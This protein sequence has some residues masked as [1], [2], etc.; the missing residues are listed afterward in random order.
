MRRRLAIVLMPLCIA[1]LV[2]ASCASEGH[3]QGKGRGKPPV[4]MLIMD[5]FP[6]ES[7]RGPDG[8]IDAARYPNFARLAAMSTWFRNSTTIYDSTPKAVPAIMD[9]RM[10]F[11]SE[12]WR[13]HRG[14]VYTLFGERG[15]EPP[16]ALEEALP[17]T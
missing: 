6:T 15:F 8:R 11:K 2:V 7:L 10:P 5:E 16:P 13:D 4:V 12:T 3:G 14:S 1:A 9:A 17:R